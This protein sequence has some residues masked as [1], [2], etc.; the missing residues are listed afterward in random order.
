[1]K[2]ILE[3]N[4]IFYLQALKNLL[5][6]NGIPVAI[7]GAHSVRVVTPFLI[8]QQS[9][10]VYVDNQLE[11]AIKLIDN[12]EYEVKNKVNITEFNHQKKKLNPNEA[13]VHFV[14]T[15]CGVIAGLYIIIIVLQ[16]FSV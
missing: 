7:N 2:L 5:E 1:M 10:W 15:L 13:L 3:D 11:E 6:S 8:N 14:L 9:L 12:P 4:D 16:W